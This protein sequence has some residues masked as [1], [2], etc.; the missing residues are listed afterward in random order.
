[1][2]VLHVGPLSN[3]KT[4][5]P[6]TNAP[7]VVRDGTVCDVGEVFP[8]LD[9][10]GNVFT[11][12]EVRK[13]PRVWVNATLMAKNSGMGKT[14]HC[15]FKTTSARNVILAICRSLSVSGQDS[16]TEDIPRCLASHSDGLDG[17]T[18]DLPRSFPLV[19][20]SLLV[21]SSKINFKGNRKEIIR[22]T[23]VHIDVGTA[24]A[25]HISPDFHA[26][27]LSI[28]GKVISGDHAAVASVLAETDRHA[29]TESLAVV[30][31]RPKREWI[32]DCDMDTKPPLREQAV[33]L[34]VY[35]PEFWLNKGM[36]ATQTVET[37]DKLVT[38]YE[39]KCKVEADVYERKCRV[40]MVAYE[41]KSLADNITP[42]VLAIR[43]ETEQ[44]KVIH[45]Q[46]LVEMDKAHEHARE[47]QLLIKKLDARFYLTRQL[48]WTMTDQAVKTP[49]LYFVDFLDGTVMFGFTGSSI[50]RRYRKEK[51]ARVITSNVLLAVPARDREHASKMEVAFKSIAVTHC[52]GMRLSGYEGLINNF[53]LFAV[54]IEKW[55]MVAIVEGWA[56]IIAP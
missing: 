32:E 48:N 6:W 45:A 4:V 9:D 25:Q 37:L 50:E 40:N 42:H 38:V 8:L 28:T 36:D 3:T 21:D 39:R 10:A 26:K 12:G 5:A 49:C 22:G 43:E 51:S 56:Q 54:A 11:Y 17:S 41:R 24:F 20:E 18:E 53:D 14:W 44:S 31:T 16:S 2:D 46:R 7:V 13:G 34:T 33:G 29:G 52:K 27:W 1:M 30:E 35:D 23:W 47:A 55:N 15:W 19:N